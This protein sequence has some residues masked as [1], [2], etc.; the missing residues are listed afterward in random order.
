MYSCMYIRSNNN[1]TRQRYII[2]TIAGAGGFLTATAV[3]G[4]TMRLLRL[5]GFGYGV[6][7]PVHGGGSGYRIYTVYGDNNTSG[8][9]IQYTVMIMPPVVCFA[10]GGYPPA[11]ATNSRLFSLITRTPTHTHTHAHNPIPVRT[12]ML[13]K[14]SLPKTLLAMI[15]PATDT[16]ADS[17]SVPA[18]S[19]SHS[20]CSSPLEWLT[21][22]L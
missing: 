9:H 12:C 19:P 2:F 10:G 17:S 6:G 20:F 5:H 11:T 16:S 3:R 7:G 15:L 21:S 14:A 1:N 4:P 18:S 8:C 22:Q 13:K